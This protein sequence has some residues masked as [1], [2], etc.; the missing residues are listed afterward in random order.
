MTGIN[1]VLLLIALFGF[2]P[3]AIILYRTRKARKILT[4]GQLE[5]AQVYHITSSQRPLQDTVYYA[6]VDKK[7]AK[8]YQGRFSIG[9]SPYKVGDT[10]D[11]Y[12]DANNPKQN[13]VQGAWGS[14]FLIW[15]GIIIGI[16]VLLVVYEQWQII[17][18][19]GN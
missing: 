12:Y 17:E 7:T 14:P 15:F 19:Q 10:L 18:G 1:I 6:F 9:V 5:K 11:V 16:M 2:L 4:T 3:L 8:Q 13:T